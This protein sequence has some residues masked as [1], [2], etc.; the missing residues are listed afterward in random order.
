MG[1]CRKMRE[2]VKVASGCKWYVVVPTAFNQA[3]RILA[4]ERQDSFVLQSSVL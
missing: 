1:L 2:D 4:A 3:D